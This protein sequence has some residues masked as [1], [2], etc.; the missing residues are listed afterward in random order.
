MKNKTQTL[1]QN[2][3]LKYGK[4]IVYVTCI[5]VCTQVKDILNNASTQ[6]DSRMHEKNTA[7]QQVTAV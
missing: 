1:S 7:A 4:P 2:S 3:V 5:T 6:C